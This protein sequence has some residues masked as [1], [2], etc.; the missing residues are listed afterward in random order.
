MNKRNIGIF[1]IDIHDVENNPEMVAELFKIMKIVPVKAEYRM[2][3]LAIEYM[4]ICELFEETPRNCCAPTYDLKITKS[5][6]GDIESVEVLKEV[7]A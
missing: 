6:N 7:T 5:N 3:W 1:R 4:A 2:D